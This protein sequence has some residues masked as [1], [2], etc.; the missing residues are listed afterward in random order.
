M[1][2]LARILSFAGKLWSEPLSNAGDSH[3]EARIRKLV[4]PQGTVKYHS[5]DGWQEATIGNWLSPN[6]RLMPA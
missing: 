2:S 6:Y 4:S 1:F 5:G 3:E